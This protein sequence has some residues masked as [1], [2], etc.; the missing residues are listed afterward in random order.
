M[1]TIGKLYEET[2]RYQVGDTS[3][4]SVLKQ[5]EANNQE[6]EKKLNLV[7]AQNKSYSD[8]VKN[9]QTSTGAATP[10]QEQQTSAL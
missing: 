6:T 1:N 10:T 5:I 2:N 8:S 7:L 4:E 9:I 3:M